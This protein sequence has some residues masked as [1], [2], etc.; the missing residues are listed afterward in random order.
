MNELQ[1]RDLDVVV[2]GHATVALTADASLVHATHLAR[3]QR[4]DALLSCVQ[5]A[6]LGASTVL[7]AR[8]G[9]DV[10]GDWLFESWEREGG[11]LDFT[12]RSPLKN[13]LVLASVA[14]GPQRA[15][16]YREGSAAATL[17]PADLEGIPWGW[18]RLVF[19]TGAT[20][21][22]GPGPEATLAR[23]FALGRASGARTV[24]DPALRA[25]Q[26]PSEAAARR[27]FDALLPDTDVLILGA[28]YATGKLLGHA[29]VD[30]AARA[31]LDRGVPQVVLREGT[32]GAVV[33]DRGRILH[34]P[35]A[36][37]PPAPSA[38]VPPLD[39]AWPQASFNGALLA[40]LARGG[41]LTDAVAFALRAQ[42]H[43]RTAPVVDV[44]RP[45]AREPGAFD[46]LPGAELW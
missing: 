45:G 17:D 40:S 14:D 18:T 34:L 38:Q 3:G 11:H 10:F 32:R 44:G 24:F 27:A 29:D 46:R 19:G 35:A 5:A 31:A 16:T 33:V 36:P 28:P 20:Q 41:P 25:H 23:A 4:G 15:I 12:R 39:P 26:W 30:D 42:S 37:D 43:T 1:G 9:D 6:R 22:L 21:A 2:I 13:A 8:V 7:V